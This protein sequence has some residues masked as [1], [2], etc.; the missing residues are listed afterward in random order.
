ME[1]GVKIYEPSYIEIYVNILATNAWSVGDYKRTLNLLDS[2]DYPEY[3]QPPVR[4]YTPPRVGEGATGA[5]NVQV[6]PPRYVSP[7][8]RSFPIIMWGNAITEGKNITHMIDS[9]VDPPAHIAHYLAFGPIPRGKV[10]LPNGETYLPGEEI[11]AA[12][13]TADSLIHDFGKQCSINLYHAGRVHE[14]GAREADWLVHRLRLEPGQT[15]YSLE[16]DKAMHHRTRG[17]HELTTILSPHLV[18]LWCWGALVDQKV[19]NVVMP[20]GVSFE[21]SIDEEPSTP[22]E[23]LSKPKSDEEGYR[24]VPIPPALRPRR[25]EVETPPAQPAP[26]PESA[27][28]AS[29]PDNDL[30]VATPEF[31]PLPPP[32]VIDIPQPPAFQPL[33]APS[34]GSI[35]TSGLREQAN[36]LR[37]MAKTQPSDSPGI[38]LYLEQADQLEA[39]ADQLES[40]VSNAAAGTPPYPNVGETPP[41]ATLGDFGSLAP[42]AVNLPGE[43]A[44]PE[45]PPPPSQWRLDWQLNDFD[46]EE[47]AKL[48][49]ESHLSVSLHKRKDDGTWEIFGALPP[50]TAVGNITRSGEYWLEAGEYEA[51]LYW[52]GDP[53][54]GM[55][56]ILARETFTI[57]GDDSG[58]AVRMARGWGMGVAKGDADIAF[59]EEGPVYP[60]TKRRFTIT[61][62]KD[63]SQL[64]LHFVIRPRDGF[65]YQC[66]EMT[67]LPM[68]HD[69]VLKLYGTFI[70][71]EKDIAAHL[72]EDGDQVQF[73]FL[74]P[75]RP[76]RYEMVLYATPYNMDPNDPWDQ[77]MVLEMDRIDFTLAA[78]KIK[79]ELGPAFGDMMS[80]RK[81]DVT[82]PEDAIPFNYTTRTKALQGMLRE[83]KDLDPADRGYKSYRRSIYYVPD[84]IPEAERQK[85]ITTNLSTVVH[86]GW[87]DQSGTVSRDGNVYT[88]TRFNEVYVE[89]RNGFVL[90]RQRFEN[91]IFQSSIWNKIYD[92]GTPPDAIVPVAPSNKDWVEEDDPLRS[93]AIWNPTPE[94]CGG[95]E[96]PMATPNLQFV[97]WVA[98]EPGEIDEDTGLPVEQLDTGTYEPITGVHP[99]YPFFIEARFEEEQTTEAFEVQLGTDYRAKVTRTKDDPLVYRSDALV[100]T[101]RGIARGIT[102]TGE[103]SP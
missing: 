95:L 47:F 75:E 76:G 2:N 52:D 56:I 28:A 101:G 57:A 24:A 96:D 25:D 20:K 103:V 78:P 91:E 46:A 61:G 92:L 93:L 19:V 32:P 67:W 79:I 43:L 72:I 39:L 18:E 82:I 44:L 5:V 27:A 85:L 38:E 3:A 36:A 8:G 74:M 87:G 64:D 71:S 77:T 23:A 68:A 30:M 89:D 88:N 73:E 22:P 65:T 55:R 37:E 41:G 40:A 21:I 4:S 51:R 94:Q 48:N 99:G 58:P 50:G 97:K 90:K 6:T 53:Q 102:S 49:H 17:N 66:T 35:D 86:D 14:G 54:G 45:A 33:E 9:Y 62:K 81:L 98:P 63:F 83:R 10:H 16:M 11:V 26:A 15:R 7:F 70:D 69:P 59:T 12:I 31:V 29:L 60:H 84:D 34:M 42:A 80:A 13:A 100:L 1:D